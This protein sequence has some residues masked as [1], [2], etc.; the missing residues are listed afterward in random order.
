MRIS[1][2]FEQTNLPLKCLVFASN[3]SNVIH[4]ITE[5]PLNL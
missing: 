2:Q 5:I 4:V 1:K 3:T